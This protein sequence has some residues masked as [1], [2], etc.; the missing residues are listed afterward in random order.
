MRMSNAVTE[1][2]LGLYDREKK[3]ISAH[4]SDI[5]DAVRSEAMLNFKKL[6]IPSSK[7]EKYKY[8]DVQKYFQGDYATNFTREASTYDPEEI[9]K[10]E[11]PNLDTAQ[12]FLVNDT[13]YPTIKNK[14][15]LPKG[16][17]IGSLNIM[18]DRFIEWFAKY[19]GKIANTSVDGVVALN[20]ALAQDGVFIYIPKNTVV[21]VPIQ[22]INILTADQATMVNRRLLIVAEENSQVNILMCNHAVSAVD[23]LQTGVTEIYAGDNAHVNFYEIEETHAQTYRFNHTFVYQEKNSHVQVN[24]M[25]LLNGVTCNYAAFQ[26]AGQGAHAD[27]NG[28]AITDKDQHVDNISLIDHAVPHCTSHELF[29]YVLDDKSKGAFTGMIL[30]RPDA[31]NTNSEQTCRSIC[32]S[33]EARM[34]GRPQLEIYADDVRCGHGATVGQLDEN[35]L[36][37]MQARGISRKEARLLLMFAFVNEVV[38]KINIEP[39]RAHLHQLVERRFRGEMCNC[40]GSSLNR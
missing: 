29:K 21:D 25:T 2:F 16:V 17:T 12:A 26:L 13:F 28:M 34:H 22:L 24:N 32:L 18:A 35:A 40:A 1:H 38:D 5:I 7:L 37:Y 39:L 11:V 4:S 19:Y 9:F 15:R 27:C 33:D 36:F 3:N 23:F 14:D 30:V 6:G 10:C 31:Q 20:T 8:T